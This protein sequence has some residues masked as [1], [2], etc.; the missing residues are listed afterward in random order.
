MA[1]TRE[2][3]P[4][5]ASAPGDTIADIL[6]ERRLSLN[7]FAK[8]I[9]QSQKYAHDLLEGR[10]TITLAVARRVGQ[11]LGGSVEFWIS[12]DFQYREDIAR[13]TTADK[14]WLD[15]LPVG[16]MI[17]FGWLH[18]IPHPSEE[19]G[20]CLRFFG[21]P[22]VSVWRQKYGELQKIVAFR[23]SPSVDSHPPSV[24][25]WIREGEIEGESINC[26]PWDPKRFHTSLTNIRHLTREP[27]PTVFVPK[28]QELCAACGV[29]V[30]IVR[31]PNGCRASGATRFLSPSKALLLLSFRFLSDDQFWFSFFH[32]AGHLLLHGKHGFFLEGD[33]TLLTQQEREANVFA[34]SALIPA[35]SR[36]DLLRLPLNGR[37]VIRFARRIGI[38][39]GIV[40]GQ[41]QHHGKFTYRQL[42]N[43]KRRFKWGE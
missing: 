26:A 24:V 29:A 38:S 9:G 11:V 40:A 35:E 16:D 21:V 27:D 12:R 20:A 2:F 14:E 5:W 8:R 36:N 22:N 17:K 18:P 30:V 28:L 37:E 6:G 7:D 42:N 31:A 33:Y 4:D 19:L 39:P 43:L 41:L 15:G 1:S 3:R 34:E 13:F 23:T 10:A 25:A 32:E